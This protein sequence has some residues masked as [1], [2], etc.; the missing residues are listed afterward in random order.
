MFK[1]PGYRPA[2]NKRA[3][4]QDPFYG[5][6]EW[7]RLRDFVIERDRYQCTEARCPTPN[8]GRGGRLIAGHIKARTAGGTDT[9]DNV[10]TFCPTCDNRFHPEKGRVARENSRW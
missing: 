6:V 7:K 9:P 4:A 10:R 8:R 3:A 1:P 5:S 2:P